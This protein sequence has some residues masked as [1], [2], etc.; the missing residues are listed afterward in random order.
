MPN[1]NYIRGRR[2]EYKIVHRERALGNIAFRSAGS[3]SC[4]DVVSINTH[5]KIIT[6]IQSKPDSMSDNQ[7]KKIEDDN[8]KLNDEYLCCFVVE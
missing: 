7:R 8:N 5:D 4:I 6:F 2:K 1:K 3:H